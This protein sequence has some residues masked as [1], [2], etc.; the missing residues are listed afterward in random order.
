[1]GLRLRDIAVSAQRRHPEGATTTA[2]LLLYFSSPEPS[3]RGVPKAAQS[4]GNSALAMADPHQQDET[5]R[6]SQGAEAPS[7]YRAA[8]YHFLLSHVKNAQDADDLAQEVYVRY[9]SNPG[10]VRNPRSY[11]F[12]IAANLVAEFRGRKSRELRFIE[13]DSAL[14]DERAMQTAD[15]TRREP[16]E[17]LGTAEL[18]NR[19]LMQIPPAYRK[20]LILHK[21]D[22][23][24]AAQI[25][26]AL[27]LSKRSVE[28]YVARAL[29]YARNA[30][31]K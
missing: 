28:I 8:L 15:T 17:E 21:R 10:G 30:L 23:M 16:A 25:A 3:I 11:I 14:C 22:R 20:V 18:L 29:T 12:T 24:T 1:M 27:G 31:W 26:A 6:A 7:E 5:A 13:V 19:I 9:L 4:D 2:N